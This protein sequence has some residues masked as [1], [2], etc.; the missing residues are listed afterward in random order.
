L[1]NDLPWAAE[2]FLESYREI[3]DGTSEDAERVLSRL[4]RMV[5]SVLR[6][7]FLEEMTGG[8]KDAYFLAKE[9][10]RLIDRAIRPI[11]ESAA[12]CENSDINDREDETKERTAPQRKSVPDHKQ[13]KLG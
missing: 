8:S 13:S 3:R 12:S 2:V 6:G 9:L 10:P 5:K 7:P 4:L 1:R 11:L